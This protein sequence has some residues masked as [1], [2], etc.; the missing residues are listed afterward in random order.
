MATGSSLLILAR[1]SPFH[2]IGT[3]L[4]LKGFS[5]LGP[6]LRRNQAGKCALRMVILGYRTS[7]LLHHHAVLCYD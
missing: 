3:A 6:R 2:N 1:A 5:A 4:A 7:V